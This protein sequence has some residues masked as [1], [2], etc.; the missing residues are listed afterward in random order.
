MAKGILLRQ[1]YGE[2]EELKK[3]LTGR[4]KALEKA[5]LDTRADQ[6]EMG[7]VSEQEEINIIRLVDNLSARVWSL[8]R[9]QE[10]V[11]RRIPAA[12]SA[13]ETRR[14]TAEEIILTLQD[15]QVPTVGIEAQERVAKWLE[16]EYTT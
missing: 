12:Y 3:D 10:S 7:L 14:D 13:E 11:E 8:E 16:R 9:R 1:A 6:G 2:I 15:G 4:I 5:I